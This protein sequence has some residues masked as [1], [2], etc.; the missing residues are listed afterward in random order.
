[1]GEVM[2]HGIGEDIMAVGIIT[3]GAAIITRVLD[4]IPISRIIMEDII[5]THFTMDTMLNLPQNGEARTYYPSEK[6]ESVTSWKDGK[7]S[8]ISKWYYESGTLKSE[9]SWKDGKLDGICKW[10]YENGTIIAE[11]SW[12]EGRQDGLYKWYYETGTLK[13]EANWQDGRQL[14][15]TCYDENGNKV[16]CRK[17]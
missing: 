15:A 4:I 10:Y 6:I 7:Q 16:Q 9:T 17:E 2:E 1:M 14:S 8:G 11:G 3:M 13:A 12:K 5:H